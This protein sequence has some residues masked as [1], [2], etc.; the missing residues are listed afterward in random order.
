MIARIMNFQGKTIQTLN[1]KS[2][3]NISFGE[4]LNPGIYFIEIR[5]GEKIKIIRA[6]KF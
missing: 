5:E 1:F 4:R 2:G 3:E 6:L